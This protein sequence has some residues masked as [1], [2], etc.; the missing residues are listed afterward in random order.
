MFDK[1]GSAMMKHSVYTETEENCH[2]N[3]K[4]PKTGVWRRRSNCL[5]HSHIMTSGEVSRPARLVGS[6]V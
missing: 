5:K 3:L 2:K 6:S 4:I 1:Q